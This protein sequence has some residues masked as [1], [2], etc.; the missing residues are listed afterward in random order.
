MV[1]AVA[2][3]GVVVLCFITGLSG[4]AALWMDGDDG[5][6]RPYGDLPDMPIV[7][8]VTQPVH[9]CARL[10][11]NDLQCMSWAFSKPDCGG[12]TTPYCYLKDV[13]PEQSYNPCRVLSY[14]FVT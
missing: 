3:G 13:I 1:M 2:L 4:A 7:L 14:D 6:D 5:V 8:N 12:E 11:Q 10:C 9:A